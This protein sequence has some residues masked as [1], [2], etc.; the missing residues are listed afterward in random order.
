M[1]SVYVL[2]SPSHD[3]IYIGYSSDVDRRLAAHNHAMNSGY[4]K[5]YQPWELVFSEGFDQRSE[6]M[7]REQELKSAKGRAFIWEIIRN[8]YA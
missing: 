8:K 6:A 1:Y 5:R 4:T 2:Y 3:E 7:R